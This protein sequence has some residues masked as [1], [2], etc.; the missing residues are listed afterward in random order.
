MGYFS[1]FFALGS[2]APERTMPHLKRG[3]EAVVGG[4][5]DACLFQAQSREQPQGELTGL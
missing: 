2:S 3:R 1:F 4:T 5:L